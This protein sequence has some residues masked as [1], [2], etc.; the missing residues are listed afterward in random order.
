[1]D[2]PDDT[3]TENEI[4]QGVDLPRRDLEIREGGGSKGIVI[5]NLTI[6]DVES[7]SQAFQVLWVGAKCRSMASTNANEHS[8]RSHTIF[9]LYVQCSNDEKHISSKISLV[10]LAGSEK[11]SSSQLAKLHQDRVKESIAINKSLS[12]LGKCVAALSNKNTTGHVPYRDSKL[13]RYL[14]DSL[15]GNSRTLFLVTLN[16]SYRSIEETVSTLQFADRAMKVQVYATANSSR[17]SSQASSDSMLAKLA[18]ENEILL[19]VIKN[20]SDRYTSKEMKGVVSS[21]IR[22]VEGGDLLSSSSS[23]IAQLSDKI[24]ASLGASRGEGR[25]VSTTPPRNN[26]LVAA[27]K[28]SGDENGKIDNEGEEEEDNDATSTAAANGTPYRN[29]DDDEVL[30]DSSHKDNSIIVD[31]FFK[32]MTKMESSIDQQTEQ[33]QENQRIFVNTNNQLNLELSEARVEIDRLKASK[34]TDARTIKELKMNL[35]IEKNRNEEMEKEMKNLKEV[36]KRGGRVSVAVP[37]ST[38]SGVNGSGG[39]VGASMISRSSAERRESAPAGGRSKSTSRIGNTSS[40][41]PNASSSSG[42]SS[43]S[44]FASI[45]D[46]LT[47]ERLLLEAMDLPKSNRLVAQAQKRASSSG[48]PSYDGQKKSSSRSSVSSSSAAA[49][50]SVSVSACAQQQPQYNRPKEKISPTISTSVLSKTRGKSPSPMIKRSLSADNADDYDY[51]PPS[52]WD[53]FS[54]SV[55]DKIDLLMQDLEIPASSTISATSLSSSGVP[56]AVRVA[57]AAGTTQ[58]RT[59]NILETKSSSSN[60]YQQQT[61]KLKHLWKEMFDTNKRRYYYHNRLTKETTWNQPSVEEM[62]YRLNNGVIIVPI[63]EAGG[64]DD[65]DGFEYEEI[66]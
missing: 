17:R 16:Q 65:E 54:S 48:I 37:K 29:D 10:D 13:T 12:A 60:N 23:E 38:N 25:E 42:S 64:E 4:R 45:A 59:T 9:T 61:K 39:G 66:R 30:I 19:H 2:T 50:S 43:S 63:E 52:N 40:V 22:L 20:L 44:K 35:R 36:S 21:S 32:R 5:P 11:W 33:F 51:T 56:G 49:S 6:V 34:D 1:L 55:S 46:S 62:Q 53:I 14:Q 57:G 15:G 47:D 27:I 41:R 31:E 18:K 7:L 8:S 24:F 3:R 28:D 58:Q 26:L